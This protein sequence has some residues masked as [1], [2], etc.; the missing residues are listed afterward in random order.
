MDISCFA[1]IIWEL[2]TCISITEPWNSNQQKVHSGGSVVALKKGLKFTGESHEA[3]DVYW[4]YLRLM[5]QQRLI[6]LLRLC[7]HVSLAT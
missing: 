5:S 7:I 3:V 1:I 2:R 6:E 4:G